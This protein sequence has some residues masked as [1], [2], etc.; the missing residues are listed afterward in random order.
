[1]AEETMADSITDFSYTDYKGWY[2]SALRENL[3]TGDKSVTINL[4]PKDNPRIGY[5]FTFYPKK[6][7][8]EQIK[9]CP[10]LIDNP[11]LGPLYK[12][13]DQLRGGMITRN[14]KILEI[15]SYTIQALDAH[16]HHV[17]VSARKSTSP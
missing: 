1:M 16:G 3:F 7:K 2:S 17:A 13:V 12:H 14:E 11:N 10:T 4:R 15:C 5:S 6:P 8:K 9:I